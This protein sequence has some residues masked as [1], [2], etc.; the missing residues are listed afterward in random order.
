MAPEDPIAA[1]VTG[2]ARRAGRRLKCLV[3]VASLL[4]LGFI[5]YIS[6]Q[7]YAQ[8][9]EQVE[10]H[11]NRQQLSLA[12]EAA[13]RMEGFLGSVLSSLRFAGDL[14]EGARGAEGADAVL[15]AL[16]A[17]L[18]GQAEGL[19]YRP[20]GQPPAPGLRAPE[21]GARPPCPEP[22]RGCLLPILEGG[23]LRAIRAQV[24]VGRGGLLAARLPLERLTRAFVRPLR[25]G[26][27]GYAWLL[28]DAGHILVEPRA[29]SLEGES[30]WELLSGE[31]GGQFRALLA[32]H[33]LRGEST[34]GA[35]RYIHRPGSTEGRYLTALA[36]LAVGSTRWTLAVTAPG[37]EVGRQMERSFRGALLLTCLGFIVVIGG[38]LLILERDRRRIRAEE[39]LLWSSRMVESKRRLQSLFDG[40]PDG[41]AIV[42]RRFRI[43]ALNRAMARMMGGTPERLVGRL[44]GK[45]NA[46]G[47]KGPTPREP[48]AHALATGQG[49]CVERRARLGDGRQ[50]DL[51]VYTYPVRDEGGGT[52]QVIVY[53][54]DVS[55]R[56][57][58]ERQLVE[59]ER[60]ALLGKMGAQVA[61]EV[62]NPLSAI[63]L[64]V[65]LLEDELRGYRGV[66]T[67][68]AWGHLRPIRAEVEQLS[69][70]V[71]DYIRFAR[72]PT[73]E[74]VPTQLN[75][76]A[77]EVLQLVEEEAA[78][79]GV[80]LVQELEPRLPE[81]EVDA[82]QFRQALLNLIRNAFEAMPAGG[83]LTVRTRLAGD[84]VSVEVEDTGRGIP[85]D[86]QEQLFTPFFTTKPQGTGLG[87]FY[88]LQIV[89]EHGGAIH[90]ASQ[91]GQGTTFHIQLPLLVREVAGS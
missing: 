41:L 62:R 11:F 40:I 33:M 12:Q 7:M 80:G 67:T 22:R 82:L 68:E 26:S 9:K 64:N 30:V 2:R 49:E 73:P 6:M 38:A 69:R 17:K 65:E 72:L 35:H 57:A 75:A 13:S 88:T 54:K 37:S 60:L 59:G 42:D 14:L 70:V 51:E 86:V 21:R 91:E 45:G 85:P 28:D 25:S 74:R 52:A 90:F 16:H 55:E 48:V 63:N 44:W 5:L 53:V 10:S 81:C 89:R 15:A 61:H 71:D 20:G 83:R 46:P 43:L 79:Q 27:R 76:L 23:R 4:V 87:L 50:V 1:A 66:D 18:E 47:D 32:R 34:T 19:E 56:R 8:A 77:E 36:P 58:L 84:R 31:R 78:R 39:Q 29:P 24:A 3:C